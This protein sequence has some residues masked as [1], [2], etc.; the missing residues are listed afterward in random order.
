MTS[1]NQLIKTFKNK[2]LLNQA[3]THRSWVNEHP[4]VKRG[5]NER[6]EFLG[7]A[8]LEYIVSEALYN[9]FPDKEEGFLTALRANLVNT[10]NLAGVAKELNL[11]SRLFLSKGEEETGGR[12]NGSLL[13]DTVEAVIGAVFLDQGIETAKNF[14]NENILSKLGD[15]IKKPLKDSK[16]RLQEYIQSKGLPAPKYIVIAESGPD[17]AK[18]FV[19]DVLANGDSLAQGKGKSKSEAEQNAAAKALSSLKSA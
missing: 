7:D 9:K 8:I 6:L 11:G 17:H 19:V 1:L 5:T 2:A 16:S 4:E 10:A 18:E 13:A 3:L 12:E 14:I 15:M